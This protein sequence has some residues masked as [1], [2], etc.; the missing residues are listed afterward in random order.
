MQM[1]NAKEVI[2]NTKAGV[3]PIYRVPLDI[4]PL[5]V[6]GMLQAMPN[7]RDLYLTRSVSERT[8]AGYEVLLHHYRESMKEHIEFA[9]LVS[10]TL[11]KHGIRDDG[12][13][14]LVSLLREARRIRNGGK[15]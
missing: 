4:D 7:E 8:A 5:P 3:G 6:G 11:Y 14:D 13:G 12:T 15:K 2:E 10:A 1:S 9:C